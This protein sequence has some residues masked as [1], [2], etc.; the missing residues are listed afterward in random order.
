LKIVIVSPSVP[1]P[2]GNAAAKWF[3]VLIRELQRRGFNV[4]NLT[5]SQD[6]P[7]RVKESEQLLR[8]KETRGKFAFRWH[9]LE[10][11]CGILKRKARNLLR[12]YSEMIY[13][14]TFID[15][16]NR[17]LADG[18]DVLNLEELW[19]GWAG[20]G[21]ARSLL[22]IYFLASIDWESQKFFNNAER[23]AYFQIQRATKKILSSTENI[24]LL[25]HRL[26]GGAKAIAPSANYFT[27]PIALDISVYPL[28]PVTE[29]PV[30]GLIGSMH[31]IPS[32]SAGERLLQNIW[33]RVKKQCP[34]A[35]LIIAG[36][37]AKK[38]LGGYLP[39][40][41][42]TIEENIS[43]PADFFSRIAVMNYAP[44][45]GSGMKVK[46]MEAMAY[47]VP[48]VTTWEGMEGIQYQNGVHCWVAES[49]DEIAGKIVE[50]LDD[51]SSRKRMLEAARA[52]MEEKYSPVPVVDQMMEIYFEIAKSH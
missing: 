19:S 15:D 48:V 12:P 25:T 37:D 43:H 24:R 23:K 27:V 36:W 16:L 38:Y 52:L 20:I 50:L 4:V 18:Y 49:D 22:N 13:T 33:P 28:Q 32:R 17:E 51:V 7:D 41:D 8:D 14:G 30:V 35:K 42:V 46:V 6:S 40:P 11:N 10:V 21:R 26:L 39:L 1:H 44:S 2:F 5:V 47:G 34:K 3:Y 29:E 45:R 9:P 31:W